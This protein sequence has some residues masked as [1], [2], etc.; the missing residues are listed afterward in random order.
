MSEYVVEIDPDMVYSIVSRHL[1]TVVMEDLVPIEASATAIDAIIHMHLLHAPPTA[2]LLIHTEFGGI[3]EALRIA[4]V[5]RGR[6]PTFVRMTKNGLVPVTRP[7]IDTVP[8]LQ[9]MTSQR[10]INE[11]FERWL[12]EYVSW[13][14]TKTASPFVIAQTQSE[15]GHTLFIRQ[16]AFFTVLER[17]LG[18]EGDPKSPAIEEIVRTTGMTASTGFW[19]AVTGSRI[20]KGKHAPFPRVARWF[21]E[22][23]KAD[24]NVLRQYTWKNSSAAFRFD[25]RIYNKD[26]AR[27]L[28]ECVRYKL[29]GWELVKFDADD[30]IS[31]RHIRTKEELTQA[32]PEWGRIIDEHEAHLRCVRATLVDAGVTAAVVDQ[33]ILPLFG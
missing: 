30:V 1:G 10:D 6:V 21:V 22:Y 9:T 5:C 27:I 26:S 23:M 28:I 18:D 20:G 19:L 29:R 15:D 11:Q 14:Q 12:A 32:N 7:Q 33:C 16:H 4:S 8:L 13:L 24:V 25:Y 2:T 17:Y 3:I 31:L